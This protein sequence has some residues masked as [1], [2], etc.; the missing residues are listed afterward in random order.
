MRTAALLD[1]KPI[2]DVRRPRRIVT[3]A[4]DRA[5]TKLSFDQIIVN[6]PLTNSDFAR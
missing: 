3:T 1:R 6:A 2:A 4:G 5:S